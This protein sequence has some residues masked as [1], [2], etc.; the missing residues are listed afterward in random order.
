MIA[1]VRNS[2]HPLP[3]ILRRAG[4]RDCK[5]IL[6]IYQTT[7][8]LKRKY[9][10]VE[11]VKAEHR[12]LGFSNWG[13]FVADYQGQALGEIVFTVERNPLM[14]PIGLIRSID[15]DIRFQKRS[16]GTQLVHAAEEMLRT[17]RVGRVVADS[18][19]EAYNF[20]MK[21][22][23]FARGS[24]FDIEAPIKSIPARDATKLT[25][26]IVDDYSVLLKD[27]VFSLV[28][29]P[30]QLRT[31]VREIANNEKEGKVL[32]FYSG[33]T[34]IGVGAVERG[35]NKR[36]W[37]VADIMPEWTHLLEEVISRTARSASSFK[38]SSV[39]TRVS[40]DYLQRY[41]EFAGWSTELCQDIPVNRF[42]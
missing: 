34:L 16:V 35:E 24:L 36:A 25:H 32:E 39:F 7:R 4:M 15:V 28:A 29:P 8:W 27:W 17:K 23:Y 12:A 20:W 31:I 41:Q 1:A 40:S 21:I 38:A 26:R 18:P 3:V 33:K 10:T 2:P 22:K 6:T 37:F 11:E 13:W 19:P 5:D 30:G 14:G 9:S 42:L